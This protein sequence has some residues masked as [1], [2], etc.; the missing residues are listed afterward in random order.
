M[1][2]DVGLQDTGINVFAMNL[3]SLMRHHFR[4][5]VINKEPAMNWN[6]P[7]ANTREHR[8]RLIEVLPK[9]LDGRTH[10]VAFKDD[11]GNETV[12]RLKPSGRY[13]DINGYADINDVH[14]VSTEVSTRESFAHVYE[15]ADGTHRLGSFVYAT[16][17]EAIDGRIALQNSWFVDGSGKASIYKDPGKHL[18]VTKLNTRVKIEE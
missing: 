4:P 10:V 16:K 3:A 15:L 1:L 13:N 5:I 8:G 6:K 7:F 2:N 12:V 14:N 11:A 18:G 9:T 17:K